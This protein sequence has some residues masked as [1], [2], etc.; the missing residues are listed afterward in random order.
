MALD[1]G[2]RALV[3]FQLTPPL[4]SSMACGKRSLRTATN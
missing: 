3:D 4:G 2:S 1:G